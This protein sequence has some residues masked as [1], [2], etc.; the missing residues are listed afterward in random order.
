MLEGF[1][2]SVPGIT[3]LLIGWAIWVMLRRRRRV[4]L[5]EA[6]GRCKLCDTAFS[7]AHI[8]YDGAITRADRARLD[9]FQARFAAFR[10][11][12]HECG[13]VNICTKDGQ[14]FAVR[15]EQT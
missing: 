11:R 6:N 1:L 3:T 7:E 12:C 13:S 5:A 8:E 10:I 14:A 4:R 2:I 9:R 15:V